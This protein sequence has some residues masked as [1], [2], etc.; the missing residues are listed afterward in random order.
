MVVAASRGDGGARAVSRT[1]TLSPGGEPQL[2]SSRFS[3]PL[4]ALVP[5]AHPGTH[6]IHMFSAPV[7][8]PATLPILAP[9]TPDGKGYSRGRCPVS[10]FP[11]ILIP[12]KL[13]MSLTH[14]GNP[15][16][17]RLYS[18]CKSHRLERPPS[19]D[20]I[21][22]VRLL[23]WSCSCERLDSCPSSFGIDP[24]RLLPWRFRCVR[25]DSCP[26]SGGIDPVRL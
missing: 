10:R 11:W 6:P 16:D 21:G 20:G 3:S 4:T 7:G 18:R 13:F 26:S 17:S 14:N 25:L 2:G 12:S 22:P 9:V 1:Q 24:V 23:L 15:P 8:S 5:V 19:S